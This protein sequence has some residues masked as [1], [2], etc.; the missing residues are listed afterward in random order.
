[1][2][3]TMYFL[4]YGLILLIVVL[5][6]VGRLPLH[7]LSLIPHYDW[8]AHFFL[9]GV[10]CMVMYSHRGRLKTVLPTLL[11]LLF[12]EELSQIFFNH[13]TFSLVD[14]LMGIM[15]V[16]AACIIIKGKRLPQ[17]G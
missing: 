9:Y 5:A 16:G 11:L 12:V 15:G 3:K 1:M 14:L 8:I 10:L 13:R 4:Y 17:P 6:D 7:S 2:K